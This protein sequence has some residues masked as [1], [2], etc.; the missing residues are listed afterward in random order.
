MALAS[1]V[2]DLPGED[3]KREQDKGCPLAGKSTL[4]R[5]ELA[6]A[7]GENHRYQRVSR[8]APKMDDLLVDAFQAFYGEE[9]KTIVLNID[10]TDIPLPGE[11]EKRF[12]R[13]YYEKL[14]LLA[15][16]GH[17]RRPG[18]RGVV[19]HVGYRSD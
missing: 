6:L 4:N 1:G 15:S 8:D 14:W 9:P 13:G 2:D 7:D 12:Y 18:A 16:L 5:L 11:Q 17:L 10:A 19:E 3:R